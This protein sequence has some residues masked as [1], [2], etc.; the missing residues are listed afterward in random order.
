MNI[1]KQAGFYRP[2]FF[3]TYLDVFN[4]T[5]TIRAFSLLKKESK[6]QECDARDD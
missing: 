4:T 5:V 2:E 1:R 6:V 3:N